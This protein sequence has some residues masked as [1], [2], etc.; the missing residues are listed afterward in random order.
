MTVGK[1]PT[2]CNTFYL[3]LEE[4]VSRIMIWRK[5]TFFMKLS[6]EYKDLSGIYV[7]NMIKLRLRTLIIE[8]FHRQ[9]GL[10]ETR[11]NYAKSSIDEVLSYLRK[12]VRT[13]RQEQYFAHACHLH[14]DISTVHT[15]SGI[16]NRNKHG[17]GFPSLHFHDL[18]RWDILIS[19][20]MRVQRRD[21]EQKASR[22]LKL[23]RRR[24]WSASRNWRFCSASGS[25]RG[26]LR[27]V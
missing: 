19:P 12:N 15:A 27:R 25:G 9:V 21:E 1:E 13:N 4:Q 7:S 6:V 11:R 5:K 20:Q 17:G 23:N 8:F 2:I 16:C 24:C 3:I 10:M 18:A 14:C 26:A 22:R